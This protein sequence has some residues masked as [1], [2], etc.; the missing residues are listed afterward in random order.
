VFTQVGTYSG[1]LASLTHT[2][3]ISGDS[4]VAGY[5]YSFKFRSQNQVGYSDFSAITR[6]GLG[7]EPPAITT[8]DSN[9]TA[10]GASFVAMTWDAI[11][12]SL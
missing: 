10:C 3:S 9:L 8:L 1:S 12:T 5:I 7:S 6:I 4:L 11:S 2:V